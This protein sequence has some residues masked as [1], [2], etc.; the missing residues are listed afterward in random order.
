M[1]ETVEINRNEI[2]PRVAKIFKNKKRNSKNMVCIGD[3]L[4][5][6][7]LDHTT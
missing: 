6:T 2:T 3:V 1:T 5:C 4:T 7:L